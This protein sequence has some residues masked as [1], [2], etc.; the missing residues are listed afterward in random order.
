MFIAEKDT[1]SDTTLG[2]QN[3]K[4][5]S[6]KKHDNNYYLGVTHRGIYLG[7]QLCQQTYEVS[8]KEKGR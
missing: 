6:T 3:K 5:G 1:E 4:F 8:E 2:I 7:P